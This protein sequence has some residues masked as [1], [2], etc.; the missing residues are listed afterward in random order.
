MPSLR[1]WL[2]REYHRLEVEGKAALV[3]RFEAFNRAFFEADCDATLAALP[4]LYRLADALGEP[5]LRLVARYYAVIVDIYWLGDLAGGLDLATRSLVQAGGLPGANGIPAFF[6]REMLF[7]AWLETDGPG[8]AS[9]VLAALEEIPRHALP[10]DLALRHDLLS[11]SCLAW[12]G[13]P[14]EALARLLALLPALDWPRPYHHSLRADA[15][16]QAGRLEEAL[17]DYEAAMRGFERMGY[18]IDGNAARLGLGDALVKLGRPDE[19]LEVL[20]AALARAE[21]LPNRAHIGLAAGL[22]GQAQA[23]RNALDEA[24]EWLRR[25][26]ETLD[27]LGWLRLEARFAL[28]RL[29]LCRRAG[30][31]PGAE[32]WQAARDDA[33]R[34]VARL[35]SD[36]LKRELKALLTG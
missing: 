13:Q 5:A 23:R 33:A 8:W 29:D 11:V 2:E 6:I 31:N 24:D 9:D 17:A 10:P 14:D 1:R 4:E 3:E 27:G 26:L 32:A 35:R 21:R 28:D 18:A 12:G 36:D 25:A 34:R 19:G 20:R 15:L 7:Y 22:L 30:C 16:A